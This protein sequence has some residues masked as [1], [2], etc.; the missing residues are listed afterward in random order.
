M[1]MY[2]LTQADMD[3]LLLAIDRDPEHGSQGGSADSSVNDPGK[4]MIYSEAHRFYNYQV[5]KWIDDVSK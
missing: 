1:K 5:R 2:M 4:R 3:R